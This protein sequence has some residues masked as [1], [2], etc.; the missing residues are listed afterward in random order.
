MLQMAR[1]RRLEESPSGLRQI[2]LG[3]ELMRAFTAVLFGV[4]GL[5]GCAARPLMNAE[6]TCHIDS[7]PPDAGEGADHAQL[8]KVYP[9]KSALN[10]QFNGCQSF[11]LYARGIHGERQPP[12][13]FIRIYFD[14]GKVAAARI[15][16]ATCRYDRTGSAAADDD[17]T[18]PRVMEAMPS[19]PAGCLGKVCTTLGE[20]RRSELDAA[21]AR[22]PAAL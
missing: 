13:D 21:P 7:P 22:T 5:I 10:A 8:F 19:Q 3:D 16:G 14:H 15:G 17:A 18:C 9:R 2:L 11:W 12:V 4:L 20:A 6:P 1:I